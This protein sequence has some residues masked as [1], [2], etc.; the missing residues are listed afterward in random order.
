MAAVSGLRDT[1]LPLGEELLEPNQSGRLRH[2]PSFNLGGRRP[3]LH[4]NM[5]SS[6][7]QLLSYLRN[8]PPGHLPKNM[9]AAVPKC[10]CDTDSGQGDLTLAV[11][12]ITV[13]I[14]VLLAISA[15]WP[16]YKGV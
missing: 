9:S 2:G 12:R 5:S 13:V 8:E 7:K 16:L 3:R 10:T 1:N 4:T 14:L 11:T 15:G 6:Y